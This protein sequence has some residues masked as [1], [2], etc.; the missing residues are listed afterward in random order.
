ML[1]LRGPLERGRCSLDLK[2]SIWTSFWN[3]ASPKPL[4]CGV[5]ACRWN[6]GFRSTGVGWL[7]QMDFQLLPLNLCLQDSP[8]GLPAN[9]SSA[10]D[11]PSQPHASHMP[12][13]TVNIASRLPVEPGVAAWREGMTR[14][15]R[16]LKLGADKVSGIFVIFFFFLL[17]I[18]NGYS[19]GH[20]FRNRPF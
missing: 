9:D 12:C 3:S 7:G 10:A 13:R 15:S 19:I 5:G 17:K 1:C 20:F 11:S 16:I 18:S 14:R 6:L 2:K 4:V 8:L